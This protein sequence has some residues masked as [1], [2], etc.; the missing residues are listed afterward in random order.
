M[1][2]RRFAPS[3]AIAVTVDPATGE[4][5]ALR[6]RGRAEGVAEVEATWTLATGWWDGADGGVRRRYFRLRTRGGLLCT[7]YRDEATGDWFLE[8][9]FD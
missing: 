1:T 5:R 2:L 9:V 3:R 6:W 4:P 7:V 8:G